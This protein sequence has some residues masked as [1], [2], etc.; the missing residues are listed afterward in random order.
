MCGTC[1]LDLYG[2][3]TH[4]VTL[5]EAH[6]LAY[7]PVC[8]S[9]WSIWNKAQSI[10][11][12]VWSILWHCEQHQSKQDAPCQHLTFCHD[13]LFFMRLRLRLALCLR[14]RTLFLSLRIFLRRIRSDFFLRSRCLSQPA[15][16]LAGLVRLMD[17]CSLRTLSAKLKSSPILGVLSIVI[18]LSQMQP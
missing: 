13:V 4:C 6:P 3:P 9:T 15:V 14:R 2:V 17:C 10:Q 7:C 18:L 5:C 12:D 11:H 1:A 8:W 16:F